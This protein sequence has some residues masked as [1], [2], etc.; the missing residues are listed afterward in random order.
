MRSIMGAAWRPGA[1]A[2]PMPT[3]VPFAASRSGKAEASRY[4]SDSNESCEIS[5]FCIQSGEI[6]LHIA[7]MV[8]R[9]LRFL[10][11]WPSLEAL[12]ARIAARVTAWRLDDLARFARTPMGGDIGDIGWE[13]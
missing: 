3:A 10:R 6:T 4:G 5:T 13:A 8:N 11:R 1:S 12:V 7:P 2:E 9:L